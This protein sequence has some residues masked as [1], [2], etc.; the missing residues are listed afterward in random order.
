MRITDLLK[1]AIQGVIDFFYP[2]F[3]RFLPYELY[4]YLGVGAFNTVLNIF[5]FAVLYQVL[6]Q[7]GVTANGCLIASYTLCLGVAF[8]LTVPTGFW[9]AKHIAFGQGG[10][11]DQESGWR[12]GKYMLVVLQGLGSDYLLM[13]GL[14][15]FVE[16]HP[17]VAKIGSTVVVLTLNYLLQK[18]FTFNGQNVANQS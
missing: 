12:L 2:V 1:K 18:Y 10:R 7:P 11:A 3:R 8:V 14:I 5:L 17:T 16:L 9:L 6:P 4:A 13:K 15:V